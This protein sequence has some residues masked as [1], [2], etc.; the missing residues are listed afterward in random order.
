ML[1]N[2]VRPPPPF[3]S[4]QLVLTLAFT[5]CRA[6]LRTARF[7]GRDLSTVQCCYDSRPSSSKKP[8]KGGKRQEAPV[9]PA[10]EDGESG[11]PGPIAPLAPVASTSYDAGALA[12]LP[13]NAAC[14]SQSAI[15]F[16]LRPG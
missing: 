11:H 2:Q 1:A 16:R 15:R 4:S 13:I 10:A 6:C 9:A 12:D 14:A 8:R 3:S 5:A 7:E